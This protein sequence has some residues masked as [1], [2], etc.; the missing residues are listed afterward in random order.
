M[1]PLNTVRI[2]MSDTLKSHNNV[3][4]DY[5][6]IGNSAAGLAAAASIRKIDGQGSI[7]VLT[8]ES[9][10][11]YSKPLITYYLAGMLELDRVFFKDSSFYLENNIRL[12]CN[13]NVYDIDPEK[14]EVSA[15]TGKEGQVVFSYNKLLIANGGRPAIPPI[16][17]VDSSGKISELSDLMAPDENPL[18]RKKANRKQFSKKINGIFTLTTLDDAISVKKY[19]ANN[20]ISSASI[21]G[22]GLIGLKAAE[23]FLELGIKINVIEFSSRIL[24][25]SFDEIASDIITEK[26]QHSGSNV[27]TNS[28]I[29]NIFIDELSNITGYQLRSG[30]K[31]PCSLLIIAVGVAPA[32]G[33]LGRAKDILKADGG[34][35]VNEYMQTSDADIYAAGDVINSFDKLSLKNKNIAIWPLA[36]NQGSVAGTNMAGGRQKYGGGFFMNSVEIL[37]VPVISIGLSS[38]QDNEAEDIKTYKNYNSQKNIYRKI[39]VRNNKVVGAILAGSIERAGIYAGLISN[40]VDITDIKDNIAKEDFGIIQLPAG[41]RKHLVVGDG[42][43]V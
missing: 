40:D 17:V 36:V 7:T 35:T 3:R 24:S 42:I 25:A 11:N 2:K 20:K 21:L 41:Y 32:T 37:G 33:I 16:K 6:I 10:S 29:D 9:H 5:L 14:H 23:A 4:T 12:I 31:V 28:T 22:G 18:E 1:R 34:I 38:A 13:A 8:N 27:L 30:K 19:I 43:E 15:D 39:V 26:I